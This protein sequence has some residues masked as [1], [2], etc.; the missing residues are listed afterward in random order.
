M[1]AIPLTQWS[2]CPL[3]GIDCNSV[4]I[5]GD[6]GRI[7]AGMRMYNG[8]PVNPVN[9]TVGFF[10]WDQWGNNLWPA[11]WPSGDTFTLAVPPGEVIGVSSVAI[12]KDG[13]W[14][15]RGGLTSAT[16]G[17]LDV[18]DAAG[19]KTTLATLPEEVRSVALNN[20]GTYLAAAADQL[21]VFKRT[22]STWSGPQTVSDPAGSVRRVAISDDGQ[23]IAAA[24]SGGWAA[25]VQN[26]MGTTVGTVSTVG[27]WQVPVGA[28][29][30]TQR[31]VQM[32]SVAANGSSFAA[33]GG[34]GLLYYFDIAAYAPPSSMQPRWHHDPP[35]QAVF[36]W[37]SV[38]DD[39]SLIAAV[40]SF[41]TSGTAHHT[42]GRVY[43]LQNVVNPA[44]GSPLHDLVWTGAVQ[45]AR[46]PNCISMGKNAAGNYYAAVADGVP[47]PVGGGFYLFDGT[48][49]NALWGS[50]PNH[51]IPTA[52]MNFVVSMANNA[53]AAAG[54]C[55][56][57]TVYFFP[58]P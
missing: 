29:P 56:D 49:G 16:N 53:S 48:N 15:A 28:P 3:P 5:S 45:T 54:G 43:L 25:L 14:A 40:A 31:H 35:G 38:W 32:V 6:G 1:A 12:S 10:G 19:I 57:G 9:A 41:H 22:G 4:A 44:P 52:E 24:V 18:Y 23:W 17:F 50:P 46:G 37:L 8:D 7:V 51:N 39:G 58:V 21:Y 11:Q 36:R 34:D 27:K 30:S 33:A 20:D 2:R 26:Q 42:K 55:N 47:N 13:N